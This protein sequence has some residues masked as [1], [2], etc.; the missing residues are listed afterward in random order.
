[1]S[2]PLALLLTFICVE[3]AVIAIFLLSGRERPVTDEEWAEWCE[4]RAE[5]KEKGKH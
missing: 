5:K 4:C 3:L 2:W 1:M